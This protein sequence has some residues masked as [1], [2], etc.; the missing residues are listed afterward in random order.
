MNRNISTQRKTAYY[1]GMGI[2]LVGVMTFLS[3]F[4]TSALSFGDFDNFHGRA[5]NS[6]MRSIVGMILIVVGQAI[7]MV[8]AR[9][10]SGSGVILDP[11]RARKD[12]H[13]YTNAVGGM[14]RDTLDAVQHDDRSDGN[15]SVDEDP[16]TRGFA[17]HQANPVIM[18]RCNQCRKINEETDKFC[19]ECGESLQ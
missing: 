17:A 9:G 4:V 6:M 11:Q 7:R 8:G 14:I 1:I 12:L 5:R 15:S 16:D 10:L 19:S 13:P 18:I 3:V 2:T